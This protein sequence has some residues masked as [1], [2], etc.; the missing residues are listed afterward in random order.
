MRA[1]SLLESCALTGNIF[2]QRR[3]HAGTRSA[4]QGKRGQV[5]RCIRTERDGRYVLINQK[6]QHQSDS[7][8]LGEGTAFYQGGDKYNG[9]WQ[10]TKRSG[11][12]TKLNHECASTVKLNVL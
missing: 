3:V 12:G 7:V 8:I 9:E 2:I 5:R 11:T 1:F 4:H 6:L 10:L